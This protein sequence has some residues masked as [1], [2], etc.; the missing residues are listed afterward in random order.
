MGGSCSW[1]SANSHFVPVSCGGLADEPQ[2]HALSRRGPSQGEDAHGAHHEQDSHCQLNR[3]QPPGPTAA[4]SD[5]RAPRPEALRRGPNSGLVLAFAM[6]PKS[7][8]LETSVTYHQA[9]R[10]GGRLDPS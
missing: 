7:D 3:G 10:D 1:K 5:V 8:E 6:N 2:D 4:W 9:W